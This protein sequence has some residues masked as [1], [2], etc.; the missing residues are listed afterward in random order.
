MSDN[1]LKL[2]EWPKVTNELPPL[3]TSEFD[4]LKESIV[5]HGIKYK[6]KVLPDGKIIDGYH[7]WKILG[8]KTPYEIIDVD[9][10]TAVAL[11]RVLNLARRQISIDQLMAY[12]TKIKPLTT[13]YRKQ[14]HTQE[15]T[16]IY[17]GVSRQVISK[18]EQEELE[19]QM[20][21]EAKKK[22]KNTTNDTRGIT[23][24]YK[25]RGTPKIKIPKSE[26][27]IIYNRWKKG[28]SQEQ[29][30]TDYKVTQKTIYNITINI[31][32]IKKKEE[33]KKQNEENNSLKKINIK[34]FQGDFV[35]ESLKI[36]VNSIDYIITDPPY[37]E[38]YL[39]LYDKLG[40]VANRLLKNGGSLIVMAGQSYLPEIYKFLSKNLTYNWTLAYLTPGG[41]AAQLWQRK[42][43][44]FWK[45]LLWYVK[46]KYEGD[47]IGDVTKSKI[48][49]NEKNHM[50]WQQS[51][52]G[53]ADIIERFTSIGDTIL[54]PFMGSGT[55]GVIATKLNRNF[56]GIDIDPKMV[57]IT[58]KRLGS[59]YGS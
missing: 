24:K 36:D 40:S 27:E 37:G 45:P 2:Q 58:K 9:E 18:W 46:G 54:D 5:N 22:L 6:I 55:T 53:M 47:W 29:I 43:N 4:A 25:K 17:F 57:E 52:S 39:E 42:V 19:K 28:E 44:T 30:A 8:D 20:R 11:S 50:E 7:R 51:E 48:N 1:S 41:Q 16:A 14:E 26:Y 38:K 34:I 13:K 12:Y 23:T 32:K 59:N 35:E 21:K 49:Q 31:E 3:S 56:I 33:E 10:E 15:E